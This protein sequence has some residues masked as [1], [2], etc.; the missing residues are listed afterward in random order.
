[1]SYAS[2]RLTSNIYCIIFP[3]SMILYNS[4]CNGK[5]RFQTHSYKRL[6]HILLIIID[7]GENTLDNHRY[8]AYAERKV[9]DHN[10]N[11]KNWHSAYLTV[12]L[13]SL[14]SVTCEASTQRT[15]LTIL[16]EVWHGFDTPG[17][18]LIMIAS[19]CTA[20][21]L[22]FPRNRPESVENPL[23]WVWSFL[24][25]FYL[26]NHKYR[27]NIKPPSSQETRMKYAKRGNKTK[28]GKRETSIPQ[29]FVWLLLRLLFAYSPMQSFL[30]PLPQSFKQRSASISIW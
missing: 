6:H 23:Q 21:H 18:I 29:A 9:E 8:R 13:I 26:K 4:W 17:H 30:L 1:M 3:H 5:C 12:Q 22:R 2:V 10:Y 16:A 27:G 7:H 28:S 24:S 20:Y 15:H 19:W 25:K 14:E 11:C